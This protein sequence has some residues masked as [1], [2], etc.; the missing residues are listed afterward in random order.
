MKELI[1]TKRED[2]TKVKVRVTNIITNEI[3]IYP[4]MNDVKSA[5]GIDH[6]SIKNKSGTSKLY[7]K[8]YKFEI[9]D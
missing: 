4:S 8:T 5:I 3:I 2:P 1:N 9:L 7:K 6:K